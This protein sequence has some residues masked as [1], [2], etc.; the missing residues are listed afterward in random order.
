MMQTKTANTQNIFFSC[1]GLR[2]YFCPH[3]ANSIFYST[4]LRINYLSQPIAGFIN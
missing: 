3:T 2:K 4:Y 1:T